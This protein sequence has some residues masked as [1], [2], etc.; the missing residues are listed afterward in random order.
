MCGPWNM[1][2]TAKQDFIDAGANDEKIVH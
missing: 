2:Q 1:T